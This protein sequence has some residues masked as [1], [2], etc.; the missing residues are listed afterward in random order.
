M[1]FLAFLVVTTILLSGISSRIS[2]FISLLYI[3]L[4]L[5][6]I[7]TLSYISSQLVDTY[8]FFLNRISPSILFLL[9]FIPPFIFLY[10]LLKG[11]PVLWLFYHISRLYFLFFS[12]HEIHIS[13]SFFI[14]FYIPFFL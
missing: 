7:P 3:F 12:F 2:I 1:Y 6:F 13:S 8:I 11:C 4:M 9:S 5:F 14:S 10:V